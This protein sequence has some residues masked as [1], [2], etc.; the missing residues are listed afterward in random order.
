MF[1]KLDLLPR[2]I[3]CVFLIETNL[4]A[5]GRR[6]EPGRKQ[7]LFFFQGAITCTQ[8]KPFL[9]KHGGMLGA[10]KKKER[11]KERKELKYCR[12]KAPS[13]F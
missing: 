5:E 1:E 6:F 12:E 3:L 10:K 13:S 4:H 9:R 8:V 7:M 11:K 2:L